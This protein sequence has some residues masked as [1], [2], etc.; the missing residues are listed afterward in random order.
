MGT[1]ARLVAE[2]VGEKT[3]EPGETEVKPAAPV[4]P[5]E[6]GRGGKEDSTFLTRSSG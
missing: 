4:W 2:H 6:Q 5:Q 3:A 1:C